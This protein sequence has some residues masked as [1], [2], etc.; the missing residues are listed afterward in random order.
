MLSGDTKKYEAH[1]ILIPESIR[2]YSPPIAVGKLQEF[3]GSEP[4]MEVARGYYIIPDWSVYP[5]I[6][7]QVDES[8]RLVNA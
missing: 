5:K 1:I 6:L 7:S 8:G 4:S 3:V 2:L